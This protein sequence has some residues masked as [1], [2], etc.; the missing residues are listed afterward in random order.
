M[1]TRD[2][3]GRRR[4]MGLAATGLAAASA[5]ELLGCAGVRPRQGA[6]SDGVGY[7]SRFGVTE[8]LIADT[9]SAARP[10]TR[11]L[12][13]LMCLMFPSLLQFLLPVHLR[14]E[15][16]PSSQK[17]HTARHPAPPQASVDSSAYA[18]SL[19]LPRIASLDYL[20]AATPQLAIHLLNARQKHH[21]KLYT[22]TIL[23]HP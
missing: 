3:M 11:L 5:S 17:T 4:F 13:F 12:W 19:R 23:Y 1:A 16:V 7:F 14:P 10:L 15:S 20:R 8:R 18:Q 22:V 2:E 6:L 9:L 21:A